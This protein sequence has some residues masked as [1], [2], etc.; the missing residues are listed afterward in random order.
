VR[1]KPGDVTQVKPPETS[2]RGV[3]LEPVAHHALGVVEAELLD[4]RA[5]HHDERL[6]AGRVAAVLDAVVRIDHGLDQRN[7]HRHVF[8]PASGHHAVHRN[9]PDRGRAAVRQHDAEYFI[10]CAIGMPKEFRHF[11]RCRRHDGQT[12]AQIVRF[13]VFVDLFERPGADYV[14]RARLVLDERFLRRLGEIVHDT[15]ERDFHDVPPKDIV[16]L[17]AGMPRH[18]CDR[19]IRH[20]EPDRRRRRQTEETFTHE[21]R[22]RHTGCLACCTGP[23]HGGR[24]ATSTTHPGNDG[25]DLQFLELARQG[26]STSRSSLPWVL[27]NSL[28]LTNLMSG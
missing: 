14:F 15:I 1:Q 6:A 10:R 28:K 5:V 8:R 21:G 18:Q 11:V 23:Q 13:E 26:A 9:A 19:Q 22:R 3:G 25:V 4:D 17:H 27:P 24:A 7:Q 16:A 20:A 2:Y 12:I